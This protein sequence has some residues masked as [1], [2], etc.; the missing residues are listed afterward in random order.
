MEKGIRQ[1][2]WPKACLAQEIEHDKGNFKFIVALPNNRLSC[3]TADGIYL[4]DFTSWSTPSSLQKP[5]PHICDYMST[6]LNFPGERLLSEANGCIDIID[7]ATNSVII[8][9]KLFSIYWIAQILVL[10][11]GDIAIRGYNSPF[12][13]IWEISEQQLKRKHNFQL[14]YKH[15]LLF[16]LSKNEIV[17]YDSLLQELLVWNLESGQIDTLLQNISCEPKV[18]RSVYEEHDRLI[19][20]TNLEIFLY[21]LTNK[22][23]LKTRMISGGILDL[24][25]DK[26]LLI[27]LCHNKRKGSGSFFTVDINTLELKRKYLFD[28]ISCCSSWN[29]NS[30]L[31]SASKI[32][33]WKID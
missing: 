17:I 1:I 15:R 28:S 26:D 32:Q 23:T 33:I 2:L 24:F 19:F 29:K 8:H 9:F 18:I 12:V 6:F 20:A 22:A 16:E 4:W 21:D 14:P 27:V 31:V 11:N 7:I 25:K 5:S 10:S 30:I 3:V 13:S